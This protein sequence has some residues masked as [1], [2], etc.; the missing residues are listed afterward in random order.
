[1]IDGDIVRRIASDRNVILRQVD[2]LHLQ[3]GLE[4]VRKIRDLPE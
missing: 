3:L 1:M 4:A 2:L